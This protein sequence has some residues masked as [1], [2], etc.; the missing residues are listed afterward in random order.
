MD[1]RFG[2]RDHGH[3]HDGNGLS[4]LS[5][6]LH[7]LPCN[8]VNNFFL[9]VAALEA[10]Q[11]LLTERTPDNASISNDIRNEGKSLTLSTPN[12]LVLAMLFASFSRSSSLV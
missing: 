10:D 3:H 9:E 2:S 4:K 6:E 11:P 8:S 5:A 1:L 12:D 7:L